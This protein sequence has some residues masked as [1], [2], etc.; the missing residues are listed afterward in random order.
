MAERD[1]IQL[2]LTR[3]LVEL[4]LEAILNDSTI[5]HIMTMLNALIVTFQ[6]PFGITAV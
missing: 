3:I 1:I 2:I 4:S 5:L 6:C